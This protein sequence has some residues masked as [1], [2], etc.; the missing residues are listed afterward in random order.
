MTMI[1][2]IRPHKSSEQGWRK[3]LIFLI[4]EQP[5]Y[6]SLTWAI[7]MSLQISSRLTLD[8]NEFM[9]VVEKNYRF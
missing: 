8:K 7:Y 4:P 9:S 5:K 6:G 1:D 3:N 2:N